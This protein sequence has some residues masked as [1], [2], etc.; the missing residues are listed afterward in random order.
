MMPESDG[1]Q[2]MEHLRTHNPN[3]PTLVLTAMELP[4]ADRRA[5]NGSVQQRILSKGAYSLQALLAAVT[6]MLPPAAVKPDTRFLSSSLTIFNGLSINTKGVNIPNILLVE[7]NDLNRDRLAGRLR[8]RD[9][10]VVVA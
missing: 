2:A 5:L 6:Q 10:N 7:D 1:F 9:Y 4:P 3:I 8:K